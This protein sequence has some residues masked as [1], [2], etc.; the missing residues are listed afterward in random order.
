MFRQTG[1]GAEAE[2]PGNVAGVVNFGS[3][4]V[5]LH[6]KVGGWGCYKE[7]CTLLLVL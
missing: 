2:S 6:G 4:G 3:D 1:N 5:V 7:G